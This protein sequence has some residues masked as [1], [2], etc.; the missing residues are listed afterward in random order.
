MFTVRGITTKLATGGFT[1][2]DSNS[3]WEGPNSVK[4]SFEKTRYMTYTNGET[5]IVFENRHTAFFYI[6]IYKAGEWTLANK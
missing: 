1:V 3:N 2:S 6:S 5:M 4:G